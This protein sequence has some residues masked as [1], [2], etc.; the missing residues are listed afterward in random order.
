MNIKPGDCESNGPSITQS[1]YP[2]LLLKSKLV[3][4]DSLKAKTA[5]GILVALMW[6]C[7]PVLGSKCLSPSLDTVLCILMSILNLGHETFPGYPVVLPM[8][9]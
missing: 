6:I 7:P 4:M 5:V 3:S 9:T 1:L 8:R 2:K